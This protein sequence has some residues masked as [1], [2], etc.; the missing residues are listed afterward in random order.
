MIWFSCNLKYSKIIFHDNFIF[1]N[2]WLCIIRI[3]TPIFITL[4]IWK[5]I[6]F[7]IFSII[8]C[9]IIKDLYIFDISYLVITLN[10]HDLLSSSYIVKI[11]KIPS[12]GISV[13]FS[14]KSIRGL[15]SNYSKYWTC[16]GFNRSNYPCK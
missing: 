5:E 1:E 4:D 2:L 14:K 9:K 8:F 13:W 16:I 11:V 7:N 12:F 6:L 15:S 10:L 3:F